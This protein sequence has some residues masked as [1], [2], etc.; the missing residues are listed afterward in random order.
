MNARRLKIHVL[1]GTVSILLDLMYASV[2]WDILLQVNDEYGIVSSNRLATK[3]NG[4]G[5]LKNLG[6]SGAD[7]GVS[8][9][10]KEL[11]AGLYSRISKMFVCCTSA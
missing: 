11:D 9:L 2:Q 8:V 7:L 1:L 5:V 3:S 10:A 6:F 4:P